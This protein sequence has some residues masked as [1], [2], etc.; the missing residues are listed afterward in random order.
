MSTLKKLKAG[1]KQFKAIWNKNTDQTSGY[2]IQYATDNKFKKNSS[3]E[4]IEDN[5]KTSQKFKD[6]KE[7]KKYYV[8]IRTYKTVKGKNYYSSWSTALTV[9]TKK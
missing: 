5:K 4:L 3:K 7:K 9:K 1:S 2:Q 8:R 6:L